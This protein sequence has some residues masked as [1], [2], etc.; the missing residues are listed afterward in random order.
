MY[1]A[2][3][4][5]LSLFG[6]RAFRIILCAMMAFQ[7]FWVPGT[8]LA[9][10]AFYFRGYNN[11]NITSNTFAYATSGASVSG[12]TVTMQA[13]AGEGTAVGLIN[14]N[15]SG[16][17]IS[18][19]I[20]LG[21]LEIDFSTLA[22]VTQEGTDGTEN[23]VP[24]VDISFCSTSDN[25][26]EI[27]SVHLTKPD[28]AVSDGVTLSSGAKIPTGTRSIFI[29]L[30]GKNTTGSNTVV[31]SNS[32]LIIHDSA[33]P[34]CSVDFN[35]NWTNSDVSV[36]ITAADS[37]A[38][39]EGIYLNDV[40]VSATSP[41]VFVVSSNNT[42]F[43]AYAK[44]LAD[45]QSDVVSETVNK[46]DKTAPNAP[47]SVPLSNSSWSNTDVSVL[48]P[49]LGA[50]SGAPERYVYQT[51][52]SGWADLT[53]GFAISANGHTTI[54]VAVEDAAG[55]R[56]SS[57]EATASIDKLAPT[58]G[59]PT[60]TVGSGST[61][62][63][64]AAT[65][66]GLS[67]L[68]K[69]AYAAGTQDASYFTTGG[70]SITGNTFTVTVGGTYTV[71]ASDNAGNTVLKTLLLTTA[72][73]LGA[74][75]DV[76]INEDETRNIQLNAAD[77]ESALS[78]LTVKVTTTNSALLSTIAVNRT[79]SGI[80]L[81]ITPAANQ[82]GG[83]A[84]VTV[85]IQ[86]PGGLKAS[87][88]FAVT[89]I[90]VNDP[91]V[92]QDDKG[93]NLDED[94]SV[95][96]DVLANDSDPAEGDALTISGVGDPEHGKAL[97]VL[98]K[99][100]YTPDQ[101]FE[102][103][104]SFSYTISDGNEGVAEANVSV[105]VNGVN[106][107]PIAKDDTAAAQEDIVAAID[108]LSND[109]DV[110]TDFDKTET[111]SLLSCTNGLHG[112]A[113]IVDGKIAY[114]PSVNYNGTDSF[115]Y[116]IQDNHELKSTASVT[117][118]VSPEPDDPVYS[119]LADEYTIDEDAKNYEIAFE[120][121]DAETPIDSLMLQAASLNTA[122]L[123][124]SGITIDGLGDSAA[125]VKLLLTPL[126]NQYGDVEIRLTLGDGFQT[127]E[128]T[129]LVHVRNVNDA[130]RVSNDTVSYT[131]GAAYV[132]IPIADL[133]ADD[134]DIE[135]D[136]LYF[137][138]FGTLTAVGTIDKIN[139]TTLRYTPQKD[140]DGQTSFTYYVSDGAARTLA[141]CTLKTISVNDAPTIT[142]KE[143][144][145]ETDED[146]QVVIPF[147]IADAESSAG[148]LSVIAAT[149]DDAIVTTSGIIIVK[150]EDGTGEVK[151]TPVTDANGTVTLTLTVSDGEAQTDVSFMLTV[152]PVQDAPIA[153]NDKI[154]VQY[155]NRR[156][157]SVLEN[158]HDVDGDTLSV[159]SFAEDLTGTLT[160]DEE[161]QT[162]TYVPAIGENGVSTFTYTLIGRYGYGHR[163]GYAERDDCD[164]CTRHHRHRQQICQ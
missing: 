162:F 32:S 105:I 31:F 5:K 63:D 102:G 160:F 72:P 96:I 145:Y 91:P 86:D 108:V 82:S 132:D 47:A 27:S 87:R 129:I 20:D 107:A 150:N 71:F 153:V 89:V 154:Y 16:H 93:I 149:S 139:D 23:D 95:T 6:K 88:T 127:V 7:I 46:I 67:G 48:M 146:A 164:P 159:S 119:W 109:S 64:I 92:A 3:V 140:Y 116:T 59:N 120:I 111:I 151:V 66:Q 38:G 69:F 45:K 138:G 155:C 9:A 30:N 133:L 161:S 42:S 29:Y 85:E 44:D 81:D 104:D 10:S 78:E 33:A 15:E 25:S 34:S 37:D 60:L 115:T 35:R 158:D 26:S 131:E 77:A 101:N 57:A 13:G 8:S 36:T 113:E 103:T 141:T 49:A 56:S 106:D 39:L 62:V 73:T 28:N 14:L 24:T 22:S 142:V 40:R 152:K 1:S 75:S 136:T 114:H 156:S 4:G 79:D 12:T 61:R 98:G 100:R 163:D 147:T 74:I 50:S 19:S 128:R 54:R 110:D 11:E 83:P 118:I 157:F 90:A 135:G 97:L 134:S 51:G 144:E 52:T 124:Q 99:I 68:K 80:S 143:S 2:K 18:A 43:S 21:G 121:S 130:P 123:E 112:T 126:A 58:I 65:E 70:T 41:Y 17:D 53:A 125:Q 122:L 148:S 84:D 55:N 76:T 137:D 94:T 117:V